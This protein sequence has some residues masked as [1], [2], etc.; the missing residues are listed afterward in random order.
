M[1]KSKLIT[2]VGVFLALGGAYYFL[3][4]S[5]DDYGVRTRTPETAFFSAW[6]VASGIALILHKSWALW[7]YASG[8]AIVSLAAAIGAFRSSSSLSEGASVG[9]FFF[10]FFAIPAFLVW[11]RRDRLQQNLKAVS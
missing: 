9:A 3:S 2:T 5:P 1:T 7:L 4:P 11:L 10:A 6:M 8:A